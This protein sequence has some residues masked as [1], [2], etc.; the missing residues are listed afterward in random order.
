MSHRIGLC[1]LLSLLATTA[2][3]PPVNG[4]DMDCKVILCLAGGFPEGCAD[5]RAYMVDRLRSFP[6]KPPFGYC[7]GGDSS[8]FRV[9]RGREPLLP[10]ANGFHMRNPLGGRETECCCTCIAA[11]GSASEATRLSDRAA[12]ANGGTYPR[13][14][15]QPPS[16]EDGRDHFLVRYACRMR[17]K[18]NWLMVRI[19][20]RQGKWFL[21]ERFWW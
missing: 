2:A 10:C 12:K 14:I 1:V 11:T 9:Y 5:A 16:R 17:P 15:V 18:P 21:S 6:P 8:N 20:S 4:Y 3:V 13:A 19:R 7:S